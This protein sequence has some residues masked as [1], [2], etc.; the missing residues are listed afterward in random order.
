MFKGLKEKDFQQRI[1]YPA[2]LFKNGGESKGVDE[3]KLTTSRLTINT[4][5]NT[6]GNYS[7][8]N[9]RH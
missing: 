5:I 3:Q 1:L 7:R 6:K 8:R 2:K 4:S 9:E